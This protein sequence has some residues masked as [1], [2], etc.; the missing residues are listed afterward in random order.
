M[1]VPVDQHDVHLDCKKHCQTSHA[2]V[3]TFNASWYDWLCILL[4][5]W[6]VWQIEP[7][8]RFERFGRISYDASNQ[9]S[10]IKEEI[11]QGETREFYEDILL[12][13][14]VSVER[15]IYTVIATQEA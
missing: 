8:R 3:V 13:R 1:P 7:S 14:E 10:A 4:N 9:R 2:Q 15:L 11:V 6:P 5:F 12:H